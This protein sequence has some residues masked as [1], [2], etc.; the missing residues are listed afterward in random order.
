MWIKR[1][2]WLPE[3]MDPREPRP[4]VLYLARRGVWQGL[5]V[6]IEALSP[7]VAVYLDV[8]FSNHYGARYEH[9]VVDASCEFDKNRALIRWV[10]WWN[11][12]QCRVQK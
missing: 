5:K 1:D 6:D 9:I 12:L 11:D 4:A 10:V 2:L 8:P 7:S 3:G